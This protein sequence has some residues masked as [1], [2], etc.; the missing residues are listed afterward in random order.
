VLVDDFPA[1]FGFYG[2]VLGPPVTWPIPMDD[3]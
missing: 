3:P 2:D 1:C